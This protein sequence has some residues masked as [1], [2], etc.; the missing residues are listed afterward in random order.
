[1][2]NAAK[3]QAE[4][5]TKRKVEDEGANKPPAKKRKTEQDE[6]AK[7]KNGANLK[8]LPGESL[9]HFNRYV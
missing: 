7:G 2:L 1:V 9:A 3:V 6:S 5:R 4:F 8:I